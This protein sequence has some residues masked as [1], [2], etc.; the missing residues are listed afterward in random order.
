M[1]FSLLHLTHFLDSD[2]NASSIFYE[3]LH[4]FGY[5]CFLAVL[6]L[7][8]GQIWLAMLSHFALDLISYSVGGGGAGFLSLYG[9]VEAI[10]AVLVLLVNMIVVILMFGGKQKKV[11][12]E[13]AARMIERI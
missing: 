4:T 12:Q 8:S 13:N 11:M 2:A 9:N 10:G 7:Y 3:L 6:Y 5:G 1:Q